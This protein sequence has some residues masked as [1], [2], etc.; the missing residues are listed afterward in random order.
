VK[1]QKTL[2]SIIEKFLNGIL[3]LI[4]YHG[5]NSGINSG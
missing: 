1:A 4:S 5:D 3:K 2:G